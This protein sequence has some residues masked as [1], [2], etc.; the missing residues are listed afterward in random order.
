MDF[1]GPETSGAVVPS[2]DEPI[3]LEEDHVEVAI[4]VD[5]GKL[6][7][8]DGACTA[9]S[10]Y[11]TTVNVPSPALSITSSDSPP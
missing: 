11:R 5:V 7:V 9:G 6:D 3:K 2:D 4:A 8:G 10:P 1:E